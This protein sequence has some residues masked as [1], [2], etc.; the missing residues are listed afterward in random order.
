MDS[1]NYTI[2]YL[3]PIFH[4]YLFMLLHFLISIIYLIVLF[5]IYYFFHLNYLLQE[6]NFISI[7]S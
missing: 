5:S 2:E 6:D 4:L 7:T 1:L 3:Y